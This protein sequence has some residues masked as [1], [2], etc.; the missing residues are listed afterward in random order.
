MV[1]KKNINSLPS[2]V[3]E[4]ICTLAL[5]QKD[6]ESVNICR[7]YASMYALTSFLG[8]EL[9]RRGASLVF[10]NFFVTGMNRVRVQNT[11]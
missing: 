11:K 9:P 2:E 6:S 1:R 3:V 7:Q 5:M 10:T 8:L 4:F